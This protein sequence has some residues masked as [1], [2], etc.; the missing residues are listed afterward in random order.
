[1]ITT[2]A[3]AW[4]SEPGAQT[5]NGSR[6]DVYP[7]DGNRLAELLPTL[8]AR[9]NVLIDGP[10]RDAERTFERMRPYLRMPLAIW[11]PRETPWLPTGTFRTLLIRSVDS[12]N[13]S[14]QENVARFISQTAGRVQVVSIADTKLFPLVTRGM[15]Q[16]RLFY[17]LNTILFE[18][19]PAARRLHGDA[20][21]HR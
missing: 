4:P 1:M 18:H 7:D 3:F 12:L 17:R 8:R 20:T 15:F 5:A 6:L 19:T 21:T 10:A 9:P 16:E 14:Q 2:I 11:A 13:A